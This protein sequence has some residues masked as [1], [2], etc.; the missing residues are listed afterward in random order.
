MR[1]II[2][3]PGLREFAT[4]NLLL[5]MCRLADGRPQPVAAR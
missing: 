5:V 2:G 3:V 1:W 4:W